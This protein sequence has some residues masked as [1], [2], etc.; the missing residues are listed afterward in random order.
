MELE[1]TSAVLAQ[2]RTEAAAAHPRECCGILLGTPWR[3]AAIRP[4]ANLHPQPDRHFEIDPQVLIEAFRAE[5]TGDT[6][7]A[8]YYHSHPDGPPKPSA[9]DHA[10]APHDGRV[11]AIVAGEEIGFWRDTKQGFEPLSYVVAPA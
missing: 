1:V 11:W 9:T 8:G 6:P 2:L 4:A 5:R 3:I 7:V 10:M